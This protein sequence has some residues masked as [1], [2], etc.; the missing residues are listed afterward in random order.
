MLQQSPMYS[1]IPVA[2]LA[3]ARHFYE[4]KLGFRPK[5]EVSGG[6]VYEFGDHTACFMYPT[7]NAGTSKASQAFWQVNDLEREVEALKARGLEFEEYDMP[8]IKTTHGIH[9]GGGTKAA[10]FKDSE[11]N[12]LALIQTV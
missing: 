7:T 11:G 9:S 2:D 5:G 8:D 10:W 3:R 1:Y 6:V 4:E 12:T